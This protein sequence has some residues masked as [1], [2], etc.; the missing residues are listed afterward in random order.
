MNM[1]IYNIIVFS[2]VSFFVP[3]LLRC[4]SAP[5]VRI[6]GNID[7]HKKSPSS[8]NNKLEKVTAR[9]IDSKELSIVRSAYELNSSIEKDFD[10]LFNAENK[11]IMLDQARRLGN[12]YKMPFW[13]DLW[14]RIVDQHEIISE[15]TPLHKACH[16]IKKD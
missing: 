12:N 10:L 5:R 3:V 1:R 4:Y 13:R 8:Y 16:L 9:R 6:H 11:N 14:A 7:F 2:I 15:E